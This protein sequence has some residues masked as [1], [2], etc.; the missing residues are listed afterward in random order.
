M[1]KFLFINENL[2]RYKMRPVRPGQTLK[3][4]ENRP[5]SA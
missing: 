3:P 1:I 2:I 4:L 5:P